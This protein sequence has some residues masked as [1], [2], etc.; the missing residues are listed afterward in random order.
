MDKRA[1]GRVLS[2]G[3]KLGKRTEDP[4]SRRDELENMLRR[5]NGQVLSGVDTNFD[6]KLRQSM[7]SLLEA[8]RGD[9]DETPL[10]YYKR[11]ARGLGKVLGNGF[12]L[13]KRRP[14]REEYRQPLPLWLPAGY[15]LFVKTAQPQSN[16]D[17]GTKRSFWV[18][19][20]ERQPEG[21]T[22][23][24]VTSLSSFY[25]NMEHYVRDL[26]AAIQTRPSPHA[27]GKRAAA[28]WNQSSPP[29]PADTE[30]DGTDALEA[31][32]GVE[33]RF[34]WRRLGRILGYRWNTK[35]TARVNGRVDR[36]KRS[37][38]DSEDEQ[39]RGRQKRAFWR[40]LGGYKFGKRST[41]NYDKV[42][43]EIEAAVGSQDSPSELG[44]Q[45]D[46]DDES[47]EK[48]GFIGVL[49]GYKL[50]KREQSM[51]AELENNL[52]ENES[53][54]SFK[55]AF[56][57]LLGGYKI[58]KR[59]QSFAN[60][61]Y[62]FPGD[63]ADDVENSHEGDATK[64]AFGRLLGGYMLGKRELMLSTSPDDYQQDSDDERQDA[65]E[66]VTKRAFGRLF[67]GS[68]LGKRQDSGNGPDDNVHQYDSDNN[69][70][71]EYLFPTTKRAFGRLLGGYL[72]GKREQSSATDYEN[73]PSDAG[74][75]TG[76]A[77]ATKRAF[78]RILGGY[79][80]GKREQSLTAS[81]VTY[82][83]E[84]QEVDD[85]DGVNKRAFGRLL[86]GY[87]L[88]K[89]DQTM[90]SS[91]SNHGP[92]AGQGTESDDVTKRVFGRRLGGYLLG[93]RDK[94]SVANSYSNHGPGAGE[95]TESDGVSKRAFGRLMG[96]Y[97]LGKR[98]Q[99]HS[100]A[101]SYSNHGLETGQDNESD[102]VIKRAFGRLMGGYLLGK[103]DQQHSYSNH[104]QGA[105]EDNEFDV[106][107]RAFGRL[108]GG[109]LLGKRDQRGMTSRYGNPRPEAD[110]DNESDDVTKRAF[111]RLLG[112]YKIGKRDGM[113]PP[114]DYE[115]DDDKEK[116]VLEEIKR[117]FSG[118]IARYIEMT[119]EGHT[120]ST[121]SI[122]TSTSPA[123]E[124]G[125]KDPYMPDDAA[126]HEY[127]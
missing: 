63:A 35:P 43:S 75:L 21:Q 104:G 105:G 67:G 97:L 96:G 122:S 92:G 98:D 1:F 19:A 93:K 77:D 50:G 110:E 52:E 46:G 57:R 20:S 79:K 2:K 14:R 30:R 25:Q 99:Q 38:S 119:K 123:A 32:S 124:S 109:Y 54:V 55:R 12:K 69:D 56:G 70:Q 53:Q 61:P 34:F 84:A 76:D 106:T 73:Y 22:K 11:E 89:R 78:G 16:T 27:R 7:E 42:V 26:Q 82:I 111:G 4:Y 66:G 8:V 3:Y 31:H 120:L 101:N 33:K 28:S 102:S 18:F 6:E 51:A 23:A 81:S 37:L 85:Y 87:L 15:R 71:N 107:K 64:R 47:F 65:F 117:V 118:M 94:Q 45:D 91:Y 125:L 114:S 72:L 58:G 103:R 59:D 83:P 68:T 80:L 62:N 90:A 40:L 44:V 48:R 17:N 74:E 115:S 13:G 10:P 95:D 86:G 60:S 88:G 5:L 116:E 24:F 126:A 100:M 41:S 127:K 121:S 39:A 112:G 36:M 49:G 9:A 29:G 108:N 113:V